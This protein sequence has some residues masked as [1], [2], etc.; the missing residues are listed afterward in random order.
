MGKAASTGHFVAGEDPRWFTEITTEFPACLNGAVVFSALATTAA[1]YLFGK[2]LAGET[3]QASSCGGPATVAVGQGRGHQAVEG[4]A[5]VWRFLVVGGEPVALLGQEFQGRVG[6]LVGGRV[7][8]GRVL[9]S[10]P[11]SV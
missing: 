11:W 2:D 9:T 8:A 7:A 1:A 5:G 3:V 10:S 4:V 6:V